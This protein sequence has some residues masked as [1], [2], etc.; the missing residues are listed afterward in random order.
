M[1]F[2][3][4]RLLSWPLAL[5]V[6]F[7]LISIF[8]ALSYPS[9][10]W[11][12]TDN[13]TL[14]LAD[15]LNM[16]YRLAD[17]QMY[18]AVGMAYHPGVTFYLMS[19]LAL[20][21][22]GYPVASEPNF[23]DTV[24][25]HAEDYHRMILCLAALAGAAGVYVFA[26]TARN[27]VPV[28]I[29]VVGLAIWLISTPA[30]LQM[31][32]FPGFDSF[33][34]I[35]NALF[36]AV[37][38]SLAY[39]DEIDPSILVFASCIGALAYLNKL[40]YIYIPLALYIAILV[41]LL[42]CGAGW[43][44]GILLL[45]VFV[46]TFALVVLA[47]AFLIIGWEG[48]RDLL[49]FHRSIILG[50]ELYGTGSRTVINKNEIWHAIVTIPTERAYAVPIALVGGISLVIG[51]LA[52]GLK[53]VQQIPVAIISIGAGVAA[54]L[55]ALIVLKH[56][57]MHYTAGVSATL[58][59][60]V[61]SGYLL[62]KSWI[63]KPWNFVP[64]F[65]GAPL[66]AIAILLMAV[67]VKGPL[68]SSLAGIAN[69]DRLAKAD[70][71]EISAYLAASK[72]TVEFAYRTPFS[73]F[74]EGFVVF[75]GSVPRMTYDYLQSRPQVISSAVAGLVTRDVGAYV[76]DKRYFPNVESVKSAP[77]LALLD[78]KPVKFNERDK[79]I[80][81]RTVFLLIRG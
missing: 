1:S 39:E 23:F 14:G 75:Y 78:P 60:C 81:L 71:E 2:N 76:L 38:V 61:V 27:L 30:T 24:I 43:R 47:A 37:M 68:I 21:L 10:L 62:A 66:V 42:F 25:A 58:P 63:T 6:V 72:R 54:V 22:I 8:L 80:E 73:Q 7:F 48:F 16:A 50:S 70:L 44:R 74:S 4:R 28:G 11:T 40:S 36:L 59:A 20:A 67:Q 31:F 53:R 26:R 69:S 29:I 79:L 18:E 17:R 35:I 33:A 45:S 41:K 32:M 64:R 5:A 9:S 77:N 46:C 57:E 56:Y 12:A 52:T 3:L 51:G 34:I 19:W 55:S 13:E 15:A 65:V 49:K